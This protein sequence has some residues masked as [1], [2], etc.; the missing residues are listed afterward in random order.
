MRFL[1][2]E[3]VGP[4]VAL[5]LAAMGHNV[6]SVYL[7]ARGLSDDQIIQESY[8]GQR[9]LITCDKDFGDLVFRERRSHGGVVL[10]R[11]EDERP[12]AI[13]PVLGRLLDRYADRL[14]GRFVVVTEGH[15]RFAG[16]SS[17]ADPR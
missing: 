17:D 7:E 2:D 15:V 8:E 11:L 10:L 5:W 12:S 6:V 1:V 3:N 4:S 9:V 13:V 14:G 16:L